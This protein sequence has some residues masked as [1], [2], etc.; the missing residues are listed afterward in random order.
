MPTDQIFL[1]WDGDLYTSPTSAISWTDTGE[2]H[3]PAVTDGAG[4]VVFGG[5][6]MYFTDDDGATYQ[7]SYNLDAGDGE[8]SDIVNHSIMDYAG[9]YYNLVTPVRWSGAHWFVF[10]RNADYLNNPNSVHHILVSY[11]LKAWYSVHDSITFG[12]NYVSDACYYGGKFHVVTTGGTFYVADSVGGSWSFNGSMTS[13]RESYR[14]IT[15]ESNG[16]VAIGTEGD[17]TNG[18]IAYNATPESSSTWTSGAGTYLRPTGGFYDETNSRWVLTGVYEDFTNLKTN[19]FWSTDGVNWTTQWEAYSTDECFNEVVWDGTYGWA[20]TSFPNA[21]NPDF[22]QFLKYDPTSGAYGAWTVETAPSSVRIVDYDSQYR[23]TRMVCYPDPAA[24]SRMPNGAYGYVFHD[25]DASATPS[26]FWKPVQDETIWTADVNIDVSE[27]T[28]DLTFHTEEVGGTIAGGDKYWGGALDLTGQY[29]IFSPRQ[30]GNYIKLDI[31][32]GSYSTFANPSGQ[33]QG[34]ATHPSNGYMYSVGNGTTCN[35]I[36][37]SA[38]SAVAIG[39]SI[40]SNH[41]RDIIAAPNGHMYLIPCNASSVGKIDTTTDTVSTFGSFSGVGDSFYS[42]VLAGTDIYCIP[43]NRSDVLKI[44]TTSDT[45]SWLGESLGSS[46][47]WWGGSLVGTDI[48]APPSDRGTVLKI[49]TTTDTVTEIADAVLSGTDMFTGSFLATTNEATPQQFVVFTPRDADYFVAMDVSDE[50]FTQFDTWT[51]NDQFLGR[52]VFAPNGGYGSEEYGGAGW[53]APY[54]ADAVVKITFDYLSAVGTYTTDESGYVMLPE[55]GNGDYTAVLDESTLTNNFDLVSANNYEFTVADDIQEF[56]FAVD[57]CAVEANIYFD[58]NANG[59]VDVGTDAVEKITGGRWYL[60]YDSDDNGSYE[61]SIGYSTDASVSWENL[62]SGDYRLQYDLTYATGVYENNYDYIAS[63]YSFDFTLSAGDTYN[64]EVLWGYVQFEGHVWCD[65]LQDG[66]DTNDFDSL[67]GYGGTLYNNGANNARVALQKDTGGGFVEVDSDVA[68]G[69]G[70][71]VTGEYLFTQLTSGDYRIVLEPYYITG[72]PT[73][74]PAYLEYLSVP[75]GTVYDESTSNEDLH[76][77]PVSRFAGKVFYDEDGDNVPGGGSDVELSGYTVELYSDSDGYTTPIAT[78]T[79][80]GSGDFDIEFYEAGAYPKTFRIQVAAADLTTYAEHTGYPNGYYEVTK[81]YNGFNQNPVYLG[82]GNKGDVNVDVLQDYE[83]DGTGDLGI[84]GVVIT[85]DG[86][87]A[88]PPSDVTD[89]NGEVQFADVSGGAYTISYDETA[90]PGIL[91]PATDG[92]ESQAISVLWNYDTNVEFLLLEE[93]DW[94][95]TIYDDQD[96]DDVRDGGEPGMASVDITLTSTVTGEV[97]NETTD[98]SG[99][100][101]LTNIAPGEW[102]WV[103]DTTDLPTGYIAFPSSGTVEL[104]PGAANTSDFAT[105]FTPPPN[106][107]FADRQLLSGSQSGR[108]TSD[109]LAAGTESGEPAHA[110]SGPTGSVWF[111]WVAFEDGNLI[112]NVLNSDVSNVRIAAYT[113]SAVNALTPIASSTTGV[114]TIPMS[115]GDDVAIALD[116]DASALS[117]GPYEIGWAWNPYHESLTRAFCPVFHV[118]MTEHN[119]ARDLVNNSTFTATGTVTYATSHSDYGFHFAEDAQ[120]AIDNTVD[121]W[122]DSL[123]G[124]PITVNFWVKSTAIAGGNRRYFRMDNGFDALVNSSGKSRIVVNQNGTNRTF[125]SST[126]VADG[127]WHMITY[128]GEAGDQQVYVDGVSESTKSNSGEI[129]LTG[130]ETEI[131]HDSVGPDCRLSDLAV[132]NRALTQE[133][134]NLLYSIP[135]KSLDTR[136]DTGVSWLGIGRS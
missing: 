48:Y 91:V 60:Y 26:R 118:P 16:L 43:K 34:I 110:G 53:V 100:V 30:A 132:Y 11:D 102:S 33:Q 120:L 131:G 127:A 68:Y 124:S 21:S 37:V 85:L 5:A 103:M 96:E 56:W 73:L 84:S 41:Y 69:V 135:R 17:W 50:S 2:S 113:G 29:V 28:T 83:N 77:R 136:V 57:D 59:V 106:N 52:P 119:G 9:R 123:N 18:T 81:T 74:T 90:L 15:S 114:L 45:V 23:S 128:T 122:T 92:G 95:I 97:R 125:V 115:N 47:K 25:V 129:V 12:G 62:A 36:D 87:E 101:V 72:A 40:T 24:A 111:R 22:S 89:S 117:G 1:Y 27:N 10:G 13:V 67:G 82:L 78:D 55:V 108:L 63:A 66:V 75:L 65:Y 126:V 61:T 38:G 80:D 51:G 86:G 98:G 54:D 49:D 71:G 134:I 70:A 104:T 39:T 130:V 42:A 121:T 105:R 14:F 4:T 31:T 99:Q 35:K 8:D 46:D 109:F 44:D 133:E 116:P 76:F 7:G 64:A 79:T 3:Q 20:T 6:T 32:D 58:T 93:C 112:V 94:T 88:T 107:D 19:W